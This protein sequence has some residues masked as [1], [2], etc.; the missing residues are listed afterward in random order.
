MTGADGLKET[1]E[2]YLRLSR[3]IDDA[4]MR[5]ALEEIARELREEA[6]SIEGRVDAR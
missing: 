2:L 6:R 3:W 5:L 1:A 4:D